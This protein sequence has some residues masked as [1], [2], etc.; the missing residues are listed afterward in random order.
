MSLSMT[1][2]AFEGFRVTRRNPGAVL[3]W[4]VVW[5]AAFVIMMIA[6]AP[7]M[8]PWMDEI[9][10]SQ[11][12][13]EALS[14]GA[15][16]AM[17]MA[18][19]AFAPVALLVQAL[20]LPAAYRA[21]LRPDERRFGYLR[22]GRD[23]A[24]ILVV[25]IALAAVSLLLNLG[26]GWAERQAAAGAGLGVGL[27]VSRVVFVISVTFSVRVSLIAPLTFARGKLAFAEGWRASGPRFWPLLG[28]MIIVLTMSVVVM[29]LLVLIGWPLWILVAGGGGVAAGVG[30]LLT[31]CLMAFGMALLSTI[32]WAP[33]A[34]I[35]GELTRT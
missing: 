1:E 23:E 10:A 12:D 24:R 21:V 29:I 19:F 14:E 31:L 6:A 18:G 32:T 5:L 13:P 9:A 33:F 26:G 16:R 22:V 2:A 7:L 28:L 15:S 30:A 8:A 35:A 34:V 4:A 20:L 27:L 17:Q 25:S 3:L 11:G